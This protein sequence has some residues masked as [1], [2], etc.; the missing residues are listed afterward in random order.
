MGGHLRFAILA[1]AIAAVIQ[2]KRD[3]GSE[4]RPGRTP[5]TRKRTSRS[6]S[7]LAC[8]LSVV[9]PLSV[10][11]THPVGAQERVFAIQNAHIYPVT[12][13]PIP[14]GVLVIQGGRIVAVGESLPIPRGA[15][16]IDATGKHVMPGI[17]ESHSHTGFKQ[18]WVPPTGTNNNELS[19]PINAEVYALDGLNTSDSAFPMTL[20]A[21]VTTMNITTGSRS[22]NSGQA[23]VVKLRGGTAR[24]M[25][26]AHG[27]MKFAIRATTPH[28]DF[29]KTEEEV[30]ELLRSELRAA[31]RYLEVWDRYDASRGTATPPARDLKY[32]ALGKLLTRE[33]MVGVHSSS[34][35]QMR[36]A[37]SLKEEFDLDL[38]IHHGAA[39]TEL[40]EEL[41]ELGIPVSRG[42]IFPGTDR[43]SPNLMGPVRLAALGGKVSFHQDPPDGHQYGI[44]YTAHLHVRKGMSE[45]D[46]LKA[47]TIN[48]AALFRLD[49]RVGSLEPGKD[50]DF[51]ILNGPPLE[52]ESIVERVFIE[53][54]EVYNRHTGYSVFKSP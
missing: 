49:G 29:P 45:E 33:W 30:G 37:M 20:A 6:T 1:H 47:L 16:V 21:G 31:Q 54:K 35:Q 11:S 2:S 27:G 48:P 40:A 34:E 24:E 43:E 39:T 42:P 44:R 26:L 28:P 12:S 15:Q 8:V 3:S 46:A 22:P 17:V 51:I 53:G 5:L 4:N 52:I 36:I 50:A 13:A 41:A 10:A 18:L 14:S 19:K 7:I 25:F 38:Y 32:E 9:L 23:V